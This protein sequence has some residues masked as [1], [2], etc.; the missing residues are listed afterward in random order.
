MNI[1]R[2]F[3]ISI[4]L[5][6]A[7][8]ASIP[9]AASPDEYRRDMLN[10]GQTY[11][12][13]GE[14]KDARRLAEKLINKKDPAGHTIMG[15]MHFYGLGLKPSPEQGVA[16]FRKA[17][18][19]NYA[20]AQA[21]LGRAV[22]DGYGTRPDHKA[23]LKLIRTAENS[24]HPDAQYMAG[25]Y[26]RDHASNQAD[27]NKALALLTR[28]SDEGHILAP[29]KLSLMYKHGQGVAPD[30]RKSW[31][32]I[33]IG[34]K[35]GGPLARVAWAEKYI[36]KGKPKKAYKILKPGVKLRI[37]H[38]QNLMGWL[39]ING[40]KGVKKNPE[41]GLKLV[42]MAADTG[43]A[44]AMANL[45]RIYAGGLG[46]AANT[47][48][49]SDYFYK[50]GMRFVEDGQHSDASAVLAEL[51]N[52]SPGS[53]KARTLQASVK[54]MPQ[55]R[56]P[57]AKAS[58]PTAAAPA[59][60]VK[61]KKQGASRAYSN[62]GTGWV[63]SPGYIITSEH[64]VRNA[65]TIEVVLSG[66]N[67]MTA[68]VIKADIGNDLAVLSVA[69]A[70]AL[71]LGLPLARKP[72]TAGEEVF[73]VG[74]PLPGDMGQRAK[75]TDGIINADTGLGDD[76]RYYQISV[77]IQPGNS[78]GPLLNMRGEV[79]GITT[80]TFNSA[81]MLRNG[82]ALPQNVN[83]AIKSAYAGQL[84]ESLPARRKARP[85]KAGRG[86]LKKLIKRVQPSVVMVVVK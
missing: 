18:D 43:N 49:A 30:D 77:P 8:F 69:S 5:I 50:S 16:S 54:D 9:A 27:Y 47:T 74:F 57:V 4:P 84:V 19:A 37:P 42:N 81:Q 85:Q 17:A 72:V 34:A 29:Y 6:A 66:G 3:I 63:V 53:R 73:T 44:K 12:F 65:K 48:L 83:Y 28:A 52:L 26:Y 31:R 14:T 45:G 67:R 22:M 41:K 23:G 61:R 76:P 2:H 46:V 40:G 60:T 20:P 15:M 24:P 56:Y 70:H 38:A 75:L 51:K 59:R 78:G 11:I 25:N 21:R 68:S 36:E 1:Y 7:I 71:P 35:R 10:R 55:H 64:V 32:F 62:S 33:K 39:L 86:N 80:A 79:I 82:G 58:V 13:K